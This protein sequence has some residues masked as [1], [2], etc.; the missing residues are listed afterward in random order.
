MAV[1]ITKLTVQ[2]RTGTGSRAATKL[3]KQGLVPAVVYGHG[4]PVAHIAVSAEELNRAIRVLHARTFSLTVDGKTDTVL[5]KE[6]QWDYLG[7]DMIHVDFERRALTERVKV[8]IPIEL[9]NAP[10]VT[11][12]GVLEQPLHLLHVECP[13]GNIPDAVRIDLIPLTLGNPVHVSDLTLPEGVVA[14][15]APDM[16]V[17]QLKLPGVEPEPAAD[18][19]SG[20]EPEVLTAK[21]PKD[22][23][24]AAS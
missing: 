24:E 7:S 16:V 23:D 18:L 4:E 3:R 2:P 19:S 17:V 8:T 5:I 22:G 15:D 21:K 9:R 10:K 11:G 12:G 6:L 1:D 20:V 13:L 14:L